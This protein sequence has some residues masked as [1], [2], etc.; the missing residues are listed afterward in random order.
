VLYLPG[1]DFTPKIGK[2]LENF[3]S[4]AISRD[5]MPAKVGFTV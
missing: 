1:D 2:E 5:Q 4:W 3:A